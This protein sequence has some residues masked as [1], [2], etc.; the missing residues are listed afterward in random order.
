MSMNLGRTIRMRT[1]SGLVNSVNAVINTAPVKRVSTFML[2]RY[3]KSRS[4]IKGQKLS[5]IAWLLAFIF[6]MACLPIEWGILY[7]MQKLWDLIK[8]KWAGARPVQ[9]LPS[10]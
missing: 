6:D 2:T 7:P 4:A 10:K 5:G 9:S 8:Y 1:R 3:L